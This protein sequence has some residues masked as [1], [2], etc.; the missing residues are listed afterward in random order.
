MAICHAHP[1]LTY[2][3]FIKAFSIVDYRETEREGFEPS[4]GF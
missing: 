1:L 3:K 4:K 2:H